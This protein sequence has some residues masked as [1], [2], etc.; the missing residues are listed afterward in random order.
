MLEVYKRLA[1]D[2]ESPITDENS[3]PYASRDDLVVVETRQNP[4]SCTPCITIPNGNTCTHQ[5]TVGSWKDVHLKWKAMP[6]VVGFDIKTPHYNSVIKYLLDSRNPD[7]RPNHV[8]VGVVTGT[9]SIS[10][11][12]VDELPYQ[13]V[14]KGGI[15]IKLPNSDDVVHYKCKEHLIKVT[16]LTPIVE[17]VTRYGISQEYANQYYGFMKSQSSVSQTIGAKCLAL[18][19]SKII[20][21]YSDQSLTATQRFNYSNTFDDNLVNGINFTVNWQSINGSVIFLIPKKHYDEIIDQLQDNAALVEQAELDEENIRQN[22]PSYLTN[23]K[24]KA[25]YVAALRHYYPNDT[26]I[27]DKTDEVLMKNTLKNLQAMLLEIQLE[28]A[29]AAAE[30]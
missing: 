20:K 12:V 5:T 13:V 16:L 2:L 10:I 25:D 22:P 7:L 17:N 24:K 6:P 1:S 29:A 8:L 19:I 30:A 23:P 27:T 18:P 3:N 4:C 9:N 14:P 11:G 15:K 28:A 26:R 21:L